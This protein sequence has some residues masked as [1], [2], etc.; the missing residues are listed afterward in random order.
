MAGSDL[1]GDLAVPFV[2]ILPRGRSIGAIIPGATIREVCRDEVAVVDQPVQTGSTISDHAFRMPAFLQMEVAWSCC[3]ES[4]DYDKQVY[5]QLLSYQRSRELLPVATGKRSYTNMILSNL[6]LTNTQQ[7]E[8]AAFCTCDLRE[9]ILVNIATGGGS[10]GGADS[11]VSGPSDDPSA[12]ASAPSTLGTVDSGGGTTFSNPY[13][14]G[15]DASLGTINSGNGGAAPP[16]GSS[17][18]S[19]PVDTNFATIQGD[20]TFGLSGIDS[21]YDYTPS[22]VTQD[23]SNDGAP[24]TVTR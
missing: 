2:T 7:T 18:F 11:G 22:F 13:G 6:T 5:A 4:A 21:Q 15:G 8:N 16:L 14:S 1:I 9:L 12:Q 3:G 23:S 19:A 24:L 20:T 10:P 17:S